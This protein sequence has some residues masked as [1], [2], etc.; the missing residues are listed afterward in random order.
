MCTLAE[1]ADHIAGE[2]V[3]DELDECGTSSE[4]SI[5]TRRVII[6]CLRESI[7]GLASLMPDKFGVPITIDL[8]AGECIQSVPECGRLVSVIEVNGRSCQEM[9]EKDDHHDERSLDYLSC[10][11][12]PCQTPNCT[13][14]AV[15]SLTGYN[16]GWWSKIASLPGSFRLQN[17]PPQTVKAKVVCSKDTWAIGEMD[18]LPSA[19]CSELMQ[20]IIDNALFRLYNIDHK[21][22]NNRQLAQSH[23]ESYVAFIRIKLPQDASF[24]EDDAVNGVRKVSQ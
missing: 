8:V 9:K 23:F 12:D 4:F 5:W 10:Y 22:G 21:D 11:V 16:P 20:P 7:A 3:N 13:D 15:N 14:N 1:L 2:R 6:K 24:L 17:P 18:N 19:V